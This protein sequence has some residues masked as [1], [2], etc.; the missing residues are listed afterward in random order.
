MSKIDALSILFGF[1][2]GYFI[3][4]ISVWLLLRY[5]DGKK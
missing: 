1:A 5:L 4:A 2:I 3:A